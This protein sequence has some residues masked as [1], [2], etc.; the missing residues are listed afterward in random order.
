MTANRRRG[1]L[2]IDEGTTGTRAAIV[3]DD[4]R[5][6][7]PVYLPISVHS[8]DHLRVEQDAAEIWAK[9]SQVCREALEWAQAHDVEIIGVSIA[10]QRA[11]VLLWDTVTG[12]R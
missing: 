3:L 1:V 8:P 2:S 6:T 4:G 7:P 5:A 9:T 11:T 12:S 10:T